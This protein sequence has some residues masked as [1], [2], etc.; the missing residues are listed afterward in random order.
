M[1]LIDE[2]ARL[3]GKINVI[4]LL[5]VVFLISLIPM[6]Y[7]V[8]KLPNKIANIRPPKAEL[9]W[10][11]KGFTV[12]VNSIFGR[13]RPEILKKISVSDKDFDSDGKLVAEIVKIGQPAAYTYGFMV[14]TTMELVRKDPE[15]LQIPVTLKLYPV[16][17]NKNIYYKGRQILADGNLDFSTKQY[18]VAVEKIN[19]VNDN[20]NEII[21][22]S[23]EY[24]TD[25]EEII[26]RVKSAMNGW[27]A[28]LDASMEVIA[29]RLLEVEKKLTPH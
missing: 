1:K 26:N 5:V 10:Q 20:Y 9:P 4:D 7:A 13:L 2:K 21:D 19:F 29:V 3:F 11:P 22:Y 23:L 25:K 14:G 15:L 18:S 12:T 27:L 17:I 8:H 16:V 6:I 24:K 28:Q